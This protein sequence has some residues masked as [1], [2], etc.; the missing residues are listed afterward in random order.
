MEDAAFG[1]SVRH[2]CMGNITLASGDE[3]AAP[4]ADRRLSVPRGWLSTALILFV[5]VAVTVS[6]TAL[7]AH[8]DDARKTQVRVAELAAYTERLSRIEWEASS[9]GHP[10][11]EHT[12]E[13]IQ[14]SRGINAS[15]LGLHEGGRPLR[16]DTDRFLRAVGTELALLG[17]NRRGQN[18][19]LDEQRVDPTFD[20][21]QRRL[22]VIG[23]A[24]SKTA[25]RA[26]GQTDLGVAAS[27]VI[28]ALALIVTL[29]RLDKIRRSAARR[30][31]QDL[32][33]Q[34]HYDALTGLPN[35]RQLEH[36]L[37]VALARTA[38]GETCIF[39][40]CDL[41][42]FKAYNDTFGHAE[43]DLLLRRVSGKLAETLAP[44]GTA[45]RLGGDEFCAILRVDR[46]ELEATVAAC[47]AALSEGG[48]GFD[49]RASVGHV[50]LP[51]EASDAE[52]TL[53][54]ADQRMY[55]HKDERGASTKQQLS[56]LALRV[57]AE[58][59]PELYT[60]VQDVGRLAEGVGR[61]LGLEDT[62]VATLV[63]AAALHDVGKIAIPDSILHK[64]GTLD[65][66]EREYMDRHTLIGESILSAAP[67]LEGVGRLVRSSHERYDGAGYPDG[68][69]GEEIPLCSRI[70]FVCDAFN[71]MTTDRPYRCAV[72][73]DDALAE[74]RRCA[75][76]QFDPAVV[77][78]F[79]IARAHSPVLEHAGVA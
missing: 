27:L 54:L 56:D 42:G 24:E 40:L 6:I 50:A 16:V 59:D 57:L 13:A 70:I 35:R 62:E 29:W 73:E 23:I 61:A 71:A 48:R 46:D 47:Q 28:A 52:T 2:S 3:P 55:A 65:A 53:R 14:V 7:R 66:H 1:V 41:D 72:D 30:R 15:V 26:A 37:N 79:E 10:T 34:A 25:K 64:P 45:Y 4:H 39:A 58:Q 78:A 22:A 8:A 36:D 51:E 5:A 32:E 60:H 49:I 76:S 38:A 17:A 11:Q 43:G 69:R 21:L 31:E 33:L 74:L 68:L 9:V 12:R 20:R 77:D 18:K 44:H 19:R 75:S 63:R 67:A